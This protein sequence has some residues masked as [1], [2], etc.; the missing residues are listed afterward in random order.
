ME[1]ATYS[2]K[3]ECSN[4]DHKGTTQLP[5]GT[6]IPLTPMDCP[7]CGCKTAVKAKEVKVKLEQTDGIWPI[8]PKPYRLQDIMPALPISDAVPMNI[9]GYRGEVYEPRM[10]TTRDG[11]PSLADG[12]IPTTEKDVPPQERP[13]IGL[14]PTSQMGLNW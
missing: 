8:R 10:H 7:N 6:V 13:V 14:E 9:P 4:C 12:Y 5:K 1:K 11:S 3:V 2:V